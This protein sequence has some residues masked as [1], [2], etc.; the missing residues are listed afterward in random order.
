MET[1]KQAHLLPD[2]IYNLAPSPRGQ[3]DFRTH[4]KKLEMNVP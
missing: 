2:A 3:W 4:K 1:K